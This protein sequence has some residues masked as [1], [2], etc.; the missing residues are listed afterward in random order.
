MGGRGGSGSEGK[1]GGFEETT[2][3][4]GMEKDL[5]K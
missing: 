2:A 3:C 4:M 1:D 5:R